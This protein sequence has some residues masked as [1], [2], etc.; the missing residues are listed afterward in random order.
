MRRASSFGPP[1][2]IHARSHVL[3]PGGQLAV[4]EDRHAELL[5]DQRRRR[6]RL[7]DR[8]A[9]PLLVEVDDRHHVERADVRM[10]P[11]MRR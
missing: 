9:A 2:R 6:E 1:R 4:E 10:E 5:A 11:G 7:R 8:R 3:G